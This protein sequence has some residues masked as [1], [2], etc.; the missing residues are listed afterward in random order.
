MKD[1]VDALF[2]ALTE[3][4]CEGARERMPALLAALGQPLDDSLT[5]KLLNELR[6]QR[7]FLAMRT[8]AAEASLV[9]E[10]SLLVFV[11]RQHA[12][13]MIE[14]GELG[15][16]IGLLEPLIAGLEAGGGSARDR[17]EAVGLLGRAWK[18]R[19]VNAVNGGSR[20]ERELRTAVA[21]YAKGFDIGWDPAWHGA[22]LVALAARAER[23]RLTAGTD[24]S[25]TWAR[26]VLARLEENEPVR[27]IPWDFA[28][29]GEAYLALGD[30]EQI[31][32]HFACYW[33]LLNAD[34]FA[35][36]GTE[37]QLRE[38]WQITSDSPDPLRSSLVV[39]LEARKLMA[40]RGAANYSPADLTALAAQL[41]TAAGQAEAT[42]GAGSAL[43]LERV[44]HLVR[45]ARSV[46]R[47]AD[48]HNKERAGTGFL[49]RGTDLV[50]PRAGAFLLTNH[51]VLRGDEA[52]AD[53]LATKDYAAS[54]D[55]K[56]AQAE[57]HFWNE[58]PETRTIRLAD[59]LRHSFRADADFT[60]ASLADPL[61]VDLALPLSNDLKPLGSR[62]V[63]DPQQRAKVILV[64]HPKGGDLSFS[65]SD[66]EVVDH[67]LDDTPRD[68]PRRI[69]YRTPTE[70]GSS[71]SPVLHH[72]TLE[73]VGVHRTGRA[74]P[75]RDDWPRARTDTI[76]E[77]NEA[78]AVRSLMG[79]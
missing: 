60:V 42:Y 1:Q 20:G 3:R 28:S 49:V 27:W 9:A 74:T 43:P 17:S 39:H 76:Y 57:F 2:S 56:R 77:A 15:D 55:V 40:S 36:A 25:E 67:E 50:P 23:D 59:V 8:F 71:G 63:V 68:R 46:C 34:G 72:E 32:R 52:T 13:A 44:L 14:L 51:H 7:C 62:N 22:N 31:A 73:V 37:R 10:G 16:A 69:H 26:R 33:N 4:G 79:L 29:A 18:Q 70:P 47:V 54:I 6:A 45:I 5:R 78:V 65:L 35:L 12:Q 24:D 19:F 21:A 61:P 11:T 41:R 66:N 38:I 30:N 64:G 48:I 53:L 75:L 58:K